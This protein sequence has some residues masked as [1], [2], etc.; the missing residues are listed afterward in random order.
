VVCVFCNVCI[1]RW[2]PHIADLR[3]TSISHTWWDPKIPGILKKNYLNYLYKFETLVPFEVL[4]LRLDVAIP[5]PIPTEMLSR[6]ARNSLAALD[7]ISV[8]D[9]RHCFQH[10]NGAGISASSRSG[11]TSKGTKFQTR[12][13]FLNIFFNNSGN[14][15]IPPPTY[16][17]SWDPNSLRGQKFWMLNLVVR[18]DH[19]TSKLKERVYDCETAT[20]YVP[21]YVLFLSQLGSFHTDFHEIWLN[22]S[23]E[24]TQI[25]VV[26][27]FQKSRSEPWVTVLSDLAPESGSSLV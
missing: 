18:K 20:L 11:S 16:S 19:S 5:A 12:T 10:L 6:A 4:P 21:V 26:K 2:S 9:F 1:Y 23:V 13:Y 22:V 8:E 7:S 14:F 24:T 27:I 3:A 17:W 15:W 25:S